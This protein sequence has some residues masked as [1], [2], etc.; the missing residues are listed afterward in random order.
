MINTPV[1]LVSS[2]R[3]TKGRSTLGIEIAAV[4]ALPREDNPNDF[5]HAEVSH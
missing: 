5:H 4:A 1:F 2:L 3:G